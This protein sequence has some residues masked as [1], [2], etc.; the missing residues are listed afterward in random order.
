MLNSTI[1][2]Y[3]YFRWL[4]NLVG[5]I[6]WGWECYCP[7]RSLQQGSRSIFFTGICGRRMKVI[8]ISLLLLFSNLLRDG[9]VAREWDFTIYGDRKMG[10][11]AIMEGLLYK[12]ILD[13]PWKWERMKKYNCKIPVTT[14]TI[15]CF[16]DIISLF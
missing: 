12:Q 14:S 1:S 10:Q 8:I 5:W 7:G 13:T 9:A 4:W 6:W 2:F 11:T 3:S 16:I 15:D